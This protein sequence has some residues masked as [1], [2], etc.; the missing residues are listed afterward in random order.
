M[1]H[2]IYTMK[3]ISYSILYSLIVISYRTRTV[4]IKSIHH[5]VNE[6]ITSIFLKSTN[7]Y[8]VYIYHIIIYGRPKKK[9]KVKQILNV[10]YFPNLPFRENIKFYLKKAFSK[11]FTPPSFT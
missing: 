4:I 11:V 10:L 7:M 5:K 9:K 8:T 2:T 6:Y 3:V 1:H